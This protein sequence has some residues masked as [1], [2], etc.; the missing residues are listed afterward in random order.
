MTDNRADS[1]TAKDATP[2]R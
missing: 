2:L 1:A